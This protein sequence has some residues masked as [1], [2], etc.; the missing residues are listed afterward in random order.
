M[1]DPTPGLYGGVDT[2]KDAHVAALVDQAGAL[3]G[4]ASFP[5]TAAG[6]HQLLSWMHGHRRPIVRV[7][8]EGTGSYGAGLSR[9]LRGCTVEVVEV[10]RPDRQARRRRGKNDTVDA[11]A[12]AR[13]ALAGETAEPKSRDGIVEAIRVIR[14]AF[15]SARDSRHR[16]ALQ[17]Q[18][19]VVSAPEPI[20]EI[21]A[22]QGVE[23]IVEAATGWEPGDLRDP[24]DATRFALA[25]LARRYNELTSDLDLLRHKLD[26]LTM[27]ANPALRAAKGVGPDVASILLSVVGDNPGR[28]R[29]EAALA[30]L[31]GVAP[32]E[33]SSGRVKRYRLNRGGDRQGNHAL[34]RIAMVRMQTDPATKEYVAKRRADGKSDREILRCL[35]R[36]IVREIYRYLINPDQPAPT[37]DL[38]PA[39]QAAGLGLKAAAQAMGVWHT[40]ISELERGI[41]RDA[42]RCVVD[43]F[44]ALDDPAFGDPLDREHRG[45]ERSSGWG[46]AAALDDV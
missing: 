46:E 17:L 31:C 42:D 26:I 24:V 10:N 13:A 29:S 33:A 15:R 5:A 41:I 3:V 16:I 7:G 12:A 43:V 39:R 9:H 14:V 20:A 37:A 44:P 22:T 6:Y 2:H 23:A 38:R 1:T 34:W 28:L 32:V 36:Y 8:V 25:N 45:R 35:K 27:E 18:D 40:R 11:I 21:L 19:I 30:A 4:T